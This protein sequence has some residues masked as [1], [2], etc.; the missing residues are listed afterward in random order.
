MPTNPD[1]TSKFK[2]ITNIFCMFWL[3]SG[4]IAAVGLIIVIYS[5]V[6]LPSIREWRL[7]FIIFGLSLLILIFSNSK[8]PSVLLS[9]LDDIR[10]KL[11]LGQIDL[12]GAKVRGVLS[13]V[14]TENHQV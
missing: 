3:A 14:S 6:L 4:I 2:L 5:K 1:P 9:K 13:T 7:G 11:S 12:N 8:A 10:Q